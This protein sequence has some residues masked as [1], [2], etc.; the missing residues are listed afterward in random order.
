MITPRLLLCMGV[1]FLSIVYSTQPSDATHATGERVSARQTQVE[2]VRLL[3]AARRLRQLGK[4]AAQEGG[5]VRRQVSVRRALQGAR[6]RARRRRGDGQG[7]VLVALL[8][9]VDVDLVNKKGRGVDGA[10]T[11]GNGSYRQFY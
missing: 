6:R 8:A 3:A 5:S 11:V 9:Q 4:L 7:V 2:H 10:E 1:I